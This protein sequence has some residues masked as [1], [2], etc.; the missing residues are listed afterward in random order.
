MYSFASF[1]YNF[2]NFKI[3]NNQWK[4]IVTFSDLFFIEEPLQ[5]SQIYFIKEGAGIKTEKGPLSNKKKSK[6]FQV[7]KK[8]MSRFDRHYKQL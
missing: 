8:E 6:S 2:D 1:I 7:I 5:I 3:L 4:F